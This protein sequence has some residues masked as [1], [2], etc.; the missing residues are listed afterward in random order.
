MYTFLAILFDTT[1]PQRTPD[2][3][4]SRHHYRTEGLFGG[5]EFLG[6]KTR[7]PFRRRTP[8]EALLPVSPESHP[9]LTTVA[10]LTRYD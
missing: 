8:E 7:M 4:V 9:A 10:N 3:K 5:Q 2:E 6:L 1:M